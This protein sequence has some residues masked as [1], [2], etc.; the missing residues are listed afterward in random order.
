VGAVDHAG[1]RSRQVHES[2]TFSSYKRLCNTSF[3]SGEC[4]ELT[5]W[6]SH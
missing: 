3:L 6:K 5:K 2:F 1:S 4:D